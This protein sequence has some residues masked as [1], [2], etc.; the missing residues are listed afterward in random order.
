MGPR[1]PFGQPGDE[2][3]SIARATCVMERASILRATGAPALASKYRRPVQRG[4]L[5][6]SGNWAVWW[7]CCS[8][9]PCGRAVLW[10][11][12]P[13][14]G[15]SSAVR[16]PRAVRL[17]PACRAT[18]TL[19]AASWCGR[20]VHGVEFVALGNWGGRNGF[21]VRATRAVG[22]G[23]SRG[24]PR[25]RTGFM[26]SGSMYGARFFVWETGR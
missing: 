20:P 7:L 26:A 23:R 21:S 15:A 14:R 17:V 5:Q 13:G 3:G 9:A 4:L 16:E 25:G 10:L 11:G 2:Q 22:S 12:K 8:G 19:V 6:R 24:Q 1:S 18:G